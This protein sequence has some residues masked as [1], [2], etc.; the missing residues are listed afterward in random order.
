[1]FRVV[2]FV[3]LSLIATV[4]A[5]A[6]AAYG[7]AQPAEGKKIALLV[8][9]NVYDHSNLADLK[10]CEHDVE[11]LAAVFRNGGYE[12]TLMTGSAKGQLRG[13]EANIQSQLTALLKNRTRYDTVI[14]ALAG[15]GMQYAEQKDS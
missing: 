5:S 1:M 10:Y 11:D 7:M 8:G 3:R 15:H 13:T 6:L 4:A 2:G 12:V 9:I 14:V